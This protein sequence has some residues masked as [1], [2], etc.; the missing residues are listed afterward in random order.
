MEQREKVRFSTLPRS[1]LYENVED[2]LRLINI[3][4]NLISHGNKALVKLQQWLAEGQ[5]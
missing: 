5:P 3:Y 2:S 4:Q 1:C